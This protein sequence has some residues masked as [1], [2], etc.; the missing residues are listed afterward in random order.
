MYEKEKRL[1]YI[2]DEL[3][4]SK[5]VRISELVKE[6]GVSRE[7]I[8]KDLR[9]LETQG[10]LRCVHGGAVFES[11]VA[12]RYDVHQHMIKCVDEKKAICAAASKYI[13][14]GDSIAIAGST[15]TGY[16]GSYLLEKNNITLL[17]NSIYIADCA[18][19]NPSNKV[20]LL[21]GEYIKHQN[22]T[23]GYDLQAM[24]KKYRVD[25]AFAS[26]SGISENGG[27]T[28][29]GVEDSQFLNVMLSIAEE[30][31]IMMDHTKFEVT[32]LAYVCGID[33]IDNVVTDWNV[34]MKNGICMRIKEHGGRII[35]AV[36]I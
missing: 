14:D 19:G 21:G 1:K 9:L 7:T 30:N 32:A 15:T 28:E 6:L 13:K 4:Q 29:F 35:K 16:L 24:L 8:R 27:L 3:A 25:K 26:G 11:K 20:I 23:I 10:L 2:L 36:Q 17:T 31:Y 22:I 18:A 33:E 12:Q 5:S 34:G